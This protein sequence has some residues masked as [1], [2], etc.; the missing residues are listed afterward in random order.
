MATVIPSAVIVSATTAVEK[1][2]S[3]SQSRKGVKQESTR[4][5]RGL[6]WGNSCALWQ[7]LQLHARTFSMKMGIKINES[8]V[9]RFQKT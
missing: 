5:K 7:Q 3:E 6:K 2:V 4:Q 8:T 9:R 1:I